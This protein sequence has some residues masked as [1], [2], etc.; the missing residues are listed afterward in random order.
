MLDLARTLNPEQRAAVE[1]TEGPL[2]ILAGAGSGK[3]RVLTY[4]VAHII[5]SGRA[6][7]EEIL[8]L[9]FTN[10]AAGEMRER[11]VGLLGPEAGR[12]FLGTFHSACLR[13]LR[14]S[15]ERV[16]LPRSFT[17]YD[18]SDQAAVLRDACRELNLNEKL[19]PVRQI[20]ARI[21]QAKN[22]GIGPRAFASR[23]HDFIDEKVAKVYAKYQQMLAANGAMDF[24]D[25]LLFALEAL[26]KDQELA[27]R[28][29]RRARYV[30]VDEYQDTNRVQYRLVRLLAAGTGNLCVVGDDDQCLTPDTPVLGADGRPRPIREI[31]AGYAV[32]VAAG[33]DGTAVSLVD[34]RFVRRHDGVL[35]AVATRGGRYLRGTPNHL[36]FTTRRPIYLAAPGAEAGPGGRARL[37]G[38]GAGRGDF[39]VGELSPVPNL[40]VIP[41]AA[42]QPGMPLAACDADGR[43]VEDVVESRVVES[44]DGDVIDLSVPAARN[45]VAGGLVVHNSIYRWRGADVRNILDFERDYPGAT[46][47]KLEQN[48]RSTQSILDAAGAVVEHNRGRKGKRLWTAQAG[49]ES[50]RHYE[51][52]DEADEAA[53]V[54]RTVLEETRSRGLR[55][56][57]AAI[58]YRVNAQSRV[59]EE[60][61]RRRKAPYVIIGGVRF[62]D[63]A[64]VKDL[65]AYLKVLVNPADPVAL[66]RVVNT[67]PRGIG[68]TTL[69]RLAQATQASGRTLYA[70]LVDAARGAAQAPALGAAARKALAEFVDLRERLAEKARTAPAADV[71]D[72]IATQSGYVAALEAE[73]SHEAQGRLE[74]VRELI[75]AARLAAARGQGA[76]VEAF[77]DSAA[78]ATS[79][80]TASPTPGGDAAMPAGVLPLMTMHNAK[81]LEFPLVFVVGLEEGLFP[82]SRS[83]DSHEELEEER[84]LCYVGMTRARQLLVLTSARRRRLYGGEP[85]PTI[86]SRF[87][88]E[89]PPRLLERDRAPAPG[90]GPH[91]GP[92]ALRR[93]PTSAPIIRGIR[94]FAPRAVRDDIEYDDP[95]REAAAEPFEAGSSGLRKGTRV[96]HV[97][98]GDGV[99]ASTDGPRVVVRFATAGVRTLVAG[100]PSLSVRKE[101]A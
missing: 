86:P 32:R 45:Y 7:P 11:L 27:G 58:F 10:K 70:V 51:A 67:P 14:E 25:L 15:A 91:V 34:H 41:L 24:G 6:R 77:L 92:G 42:V 57:D 74:N 1:T 64:E 95:P 3:T 59:L 48:Y 28:Y 62:Y 79:A 71:L 61:L 84:R 68:K 83:L 56:E 37:G 85:T 44:Y 35:V 60:E 30:H 40:R 17:V 36:V 81:G 20:A 54:V 75:A 72:A 87:L 93:G 76:S 65:L 2:L 96:H 89:I 94:G 29:R 13:I 21:D 97:V 69:D 22:E 88:T 47:V 80:D 39:G 100:H 38:R 63:R 55:L 23:P 12:V 49:G 52:A 98:F 9:T 99:V 43:I 66:L 16:G 101:G 90:F 4:R 82:H 19:F 73:P 26:E 5:R 31:H 33:G 8:A 46:V 78:L 18:E 53:Y 50:P